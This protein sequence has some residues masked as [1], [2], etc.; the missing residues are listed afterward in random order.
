MLPLGLDRERGKSGAGTCH[1]WAP[2][3]PNHQVGLPQ[4]QPPDPPP[5]TPNTRNDQAWVKVETVTIKMPWGGGETLWPGVRRPEFKNLAL[6]PILCVLLVNSFLLSKFTGLYLSNFGNRMTC[7]GVRQ[8]RLESQLHLL[9][10]LLATW[11]PASALISLSLN[12]ITCN[13]AIIIISNSY[14]C[15]N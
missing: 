6:P 14:G 2:P 10:Y 4:A 1:S 13:G 5:Q 7:F 8:T 3:Q 12:F 15:E 11:T 9:V